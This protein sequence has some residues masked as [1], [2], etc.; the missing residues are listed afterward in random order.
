MQPQFSQKREVNLDQNEDLTGAA[1][2]AL[3]HLRAMRSMMD[4]IRA[5]AWQMRA[6]F[7]SLMISNTLAAD[8]R[9]ADPKSLARFNRRMYSQHGED[10]VIAEIFNRVGRNNRT[11]LEI[12]VGDGRQNTTR[13]LLEQGWRGTWIEGSENDCLSARDFLSGYIDSGALKIVSAFVTA[14]NINALLDEAKV[15]EL[16]DYIS[17]DVDMN[18]GYIWEAIKRRSR[19]A[20]IEYNCTM[21][22]NAAM[23]VPYDSSAVWDGSAWY[24]SSVKK[25]ERIGQSKNMALVGCD[26][27]GVNAYF[28]ESSEAQGKFREPFTAETHYEPPRYYPMGSQH[29]PP[30]QPRPWIIE[31]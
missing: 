9:Y 6:C 11:F 8:G 31:D 26:L 29:Q 3:E 16:I 1:V 18:T 5:D 27:V 25:L 4:Q 15:P 28:V 2:E 7:E 10:G 13:Y 23:T 20:C 19:V 17:V 14:E 22:A 30:R 24:G 21:P 12:G